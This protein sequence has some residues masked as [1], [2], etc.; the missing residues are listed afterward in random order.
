M[1]RLERTRGTVDN[2]R[3]RCAVIPGCPAER[4]NVDHRLLSIRSAWA[5]STNQRTSLMEVVA[6]ASGDG[7]L[8]RLFTLCAGREKFEQHGVAFTVEF[9]DRG[10]L[11]SF[12]ESRQD[13]SNLTDSSPEVSTIMT[14]E[15]RHRGR[16]NSTVKRDAMLLETSP[17][18]AQRVKRRHKQPSPE[19]TA[20]SFHQ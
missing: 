1:E 4:M 6:V 5:R 11:A 15:S 16:R 19:A 18:P 12:V 9:V 14:A 10:E 13:R 2:Q 17:R 7:C 3:V 20:T 8:C